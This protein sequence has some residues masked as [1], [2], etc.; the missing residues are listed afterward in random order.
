MNFKSTTQPFCLTCSR[1]I[2]KATEHHFL[3]QS[4][5][6]LAQVKASTNR[7]VVFWRYADE[8]GELAVTYQKRPGGGYGDLEFETRAKSKTLIDEFS[9]W[10]GESY[11]DEFFCTGTCAQRYGYRMA[12]LVKQHNKERAA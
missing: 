10:D 2:A 12:R 11:V 4:P 9:T 5:Q 6:T 7:Q 3:R 8:P 1:K